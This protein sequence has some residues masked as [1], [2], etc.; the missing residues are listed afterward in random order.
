MAKSPPISVVA[1]PTLNFI[2]PALPVAAFPVDTE[3]APED[4]ELVVPV[5]KFK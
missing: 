3:T 4:P 2:S 5:A 1:V